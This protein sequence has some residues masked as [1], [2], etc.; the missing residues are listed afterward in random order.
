MANE[1]RSRLV[2]TTSSRFRKSKRFV[3]LPVVAEMIPKTVLSGLRFL[4][5][6]KR[7]EKYAT[8]SA[9]AIDMTV[10]MKRRTRNRIAK[11]IN[12]R[13]MARRI[14]KTGIGAEM[15]PSVMGTV[16]SSNRAFPPVSLFMCIS[17]LSLEA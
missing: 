12:P 5:L 7:T 16:S 13:D 6:Q 4:H 11:S 14:Y 17:V 3:E 9:N 15:K 8:V 1:A 2:A 10:A